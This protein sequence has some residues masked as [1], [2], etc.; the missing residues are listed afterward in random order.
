MAPLAAVAMVVTV[1]LAAAFLA[2]QPVMV[3]AP[4]VGM[5][6]TPEVVVAEGVVGEAG[7]EVVKPTVAG[8]AADITISLTAIVQH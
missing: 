7:V 1:M 4:V 2:L 5:M 6:P 8:V 3:P